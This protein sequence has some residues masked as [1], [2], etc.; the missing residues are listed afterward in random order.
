MPIKCPRGMIVRKGGKVKSFTRASGIKV[1]SSR[2]RSACTPS[3]GRF[4]PGRAPASARILPKPVK[5][6]LGKYGYANVKNKAAGKRHTAL[7]KGVR[8]A[9]Y[10]TIVRRLNLIANFTKTSDPVANRIY[11]SDIKWLQTNAKKRYSVAGTRRGASGITG[12]SKAG[13]YIDR[14]G[15]R[16]QLYRSKGAARKFY[17]YRLASGGMGRRY[18]D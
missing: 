9:G 10:A 6:N 3:K 12:I 2:R 16:H 7:M 15:R 13:T 8:D 4:Y 18:V 5:G 17:R 11:R 14:N 1:R